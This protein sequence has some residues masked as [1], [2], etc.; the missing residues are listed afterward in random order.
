[1]PPVKMTR[2]P[3]WGALA[4]LGRG[5]QHPVSIVL[6]GSAAVVLGE[7]LLRPT[8][9][10][11]V[12]ASEPGLGDLQALIRDVADSEGLSTGWLNGS[13]PSYTYILPKDYPSRLESLPSFNR[14]HLRLLGRHDVILMKVH[15]MRPRDVEDLRATRPTN[16]EL[17]FVRTQLPRFSAEEPEKARDMGAF[18]DEWSE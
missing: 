16:E 10:G 11:D 1:M 3:L 5:A 18:L 14:L 17:A 9:D 2:D 7:D 12:V 13:I 15:G 4:A 6:G 8:D